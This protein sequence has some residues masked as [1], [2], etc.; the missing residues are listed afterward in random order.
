MLKEIKPGIYYVIHEGGMDF[1]KP[2]EFPDETG[3]VFLK[4]IS[5]DFHAKD[6]FRYESDTQA[7]VSK[8]QTAN[9]EVEYTEGM[10]QRFERSAYTATISFRIDD[11][12]ML[13]GL[14]QG[15]DGIYNLRD[16]TVYLYQSNMRIAIPFVISTGNYGILLDTESAVV[17]QCKDN[18]IT[19]SIDTCD[20]IKYY[21]IRGGNFDEIIG[22]LREVTGRASM[23]PRWAFGYFQSK[24]RYQS[25]EELV[26]VTR[27]FRELNIPLDCIVQDW[28][29]WG[30]G[31]WGEKIPD[32]RRYHS[33]KDLT[34]QLHGMNTKLMLSIWP[35]M[36]KGSE[37]YKEMESLGY[38]L[39]NSNVYDA[40]HDG[41]RETYWK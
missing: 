14:G 39:P 20:E 6:V 3:E 5:H 36:A 9:G 30:D 28:L 17:Y 7:S 11:D 37:N 12:E 32:Q 35:N 10:A 13:F 22:Y 34:G 40:Y 23:L 33:V 38:L 25:S 41:A 16:R 8:K 2:I 15:E 31:L 4:E 29:S 27:K 19:F 26:D 24:E 1:E 18:V 21:V